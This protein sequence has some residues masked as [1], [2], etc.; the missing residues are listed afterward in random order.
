MTMAAPLKLGLLVTTVPAM[1]I[2]EIAQ[3][4][5]EMGFDD[6]WTGEHFALHR[7]DWWHEESSVKAKLK[8][9]LPA[10]PEDAH[11]RPTDLFEDAMLMMAA[12]AGATK[13]IRLGF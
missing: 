7:D 11:V 3:A 13:R 8:A 4:A 10:G 9:G 1:H 5:E 12:V 6:V 2:V